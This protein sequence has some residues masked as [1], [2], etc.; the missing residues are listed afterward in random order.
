MKAT[1]REFG[2]SFLAG[3][4]PFDDGL[5]AGVREYGRRIGRLLK[6]AYWNLLAVVVLWALT[7][8]APG[9]VRAVGGLGALA[10]MFVSRERVFVHALAEWRRD[11]SAACNWIRGSLTAVTDRW[12][13]LFPALGTSLIAACVALLMFAS[14]PAVSALKWPKALSAPLLF[15]AT[16]VAACSALLM[17]ASVQAVFR[18]SQRMAAQPGQVG[19]PPPPGQ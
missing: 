14:A 2:Q 10:L 8:P 1:S 9:F 12:P 3:R 7:Q 17:L 16:L 11:L 4:L 6:V 15:S 19:S 13:E 18:A 5:A